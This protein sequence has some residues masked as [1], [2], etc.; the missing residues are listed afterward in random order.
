MLWGENQTTKAWAI[1]SKFTYDDESVAEI[2]R[3]TTNYVED[4]HCTIYPIQGKFCQE[5]SE[6]MLVMVKYLSNAVGRPFVEVI[7]DFIRDRDDQWWFLQV[8]A[9]RIKDGV[10][11]LSGMEMIRSETSLLL[12]DKSG[13]LKQKRIEAEALQLPEDKTKEVVISDGEDEEETQKGDSNSRKYTTCACCGVGYQS[14]QLPYKMTYN[15]VKELKTNI[16]IRCGNKDDAWTSVSAHLA[17]KGEKLRLSDMAFLYQPLCVCTLCY[18]VYRAEQKLR[19]VS[20]ALARAMGVPAPAVYINIYL[21]LY[22]LFF[23]FSFFCYFILFFNLIFAYS[24]KK[25]IIKMVVNYP[26]YQMIQVLN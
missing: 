10:P 8:K 1:I 19:A 26:N 25:L 21:I 6:I 20:S 12:M 18:K 5:L 3:F 11:T 23:F 24:S 17:K 2:D 16:K 13:V 22:I 15:M 4:N 9:F 7:A 14:F